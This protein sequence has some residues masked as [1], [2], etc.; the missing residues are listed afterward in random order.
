MSRIYTPVGHQILCKRINSEKRTASGLH[1]PESRQQL[2]VEGEVLAVGPGDFDGF[3][4]NP[5]WRAA[6][7]PT[8]INTLAGQ[9]WQDVADDRGPHE[10]EMLFARYKPMPCKVGELVIT[11]GH[12][13][14]LEDGL[15]L[16]CATDIWATFTGGN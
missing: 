5:D 6:P 7:V 4:A 15:F 13:T 14:E 16:V 8:R 1:L 12:I 2:A 3:Y 9:R 10:R 11:S